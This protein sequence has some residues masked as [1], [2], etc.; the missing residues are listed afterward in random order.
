MSIVSIATIVYNKPKFIEYQYR[1]FIKF[2][3]NKFDYIVYDNAIDINIKKEISSVCNKLC[4]PVI[5][6]VNNSGDDSTRAGISL[7]Y[8]INDMRKRSNTNVILIDS[9]MFLAD[10]YDAVESLG[11]Y[12]LLG[13]PN[14]KKGEKIGCI[15]YYTNQFLHMNLS[16]LPIDNDFSFIPATIDNTRVDCGGSLYNYFIKYPEIK[17][18]AIRVI[19]GT[20]TTIYEIEK[21]PNHSKFLIDFFK[22]ERDIFKF[23]NNS[24]FSELFQ[25][26]FVH[27]R[28]GSNWIGIDVEKQKQREENLYN[29]INTL[30]K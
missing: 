28:A 17:H 8:A 13:N 5:N 23:E 10:Y 11:D 30:T 12:D 4:I 27:L 6:V 18:R 15:P 22:K 2:I 21:I 25:D 29:L 20:P 1:S 3:K 16:R 14:C 9:D 26:V 19:N 7:N 24:N